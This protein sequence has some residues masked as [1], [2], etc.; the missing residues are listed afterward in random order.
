[1]Q[2]PTR[3]GLASER[4]TRDSEMVSKNEI[5]SAAISGGVAVQ[6]MSRTR[7]SAGRVVE[8]TL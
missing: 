7:A 2:P 6:A 5:G 3:R 4:F 1:M 8:A